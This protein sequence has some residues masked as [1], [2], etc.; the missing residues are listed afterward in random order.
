MLR[1]IPILKQSTSPSP[2]CVLRDPQGDMVELK[3]IISILYYAQQNLLPR[4][5]AKLD[6]VTLS[7][8]IEVKSQDTVVRTI[9]A[10]E[11]PVVISF[12]INNYSIE[13]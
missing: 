9:Y 6:V 10:G 11:I 4:V 2:L 7:D 5:S 1:N 12:I 8:I 13:V 3:N